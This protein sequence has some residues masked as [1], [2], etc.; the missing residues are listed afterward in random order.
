MPGENPRMHHTTVPPCLI[1]CMC[2]FIRVELLGELGFA[3]ISV[4]TRMITSSSHS[5]SIGANML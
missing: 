2:K 4:E 3:G 5:V 1:M